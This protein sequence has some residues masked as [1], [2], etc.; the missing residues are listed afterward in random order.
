[1]K[2]AFNARRITENVWWVG[3]IDWELRN[4]H[5]YLTSQGSTYNAYLITGS[6]PIL[7]D[8]VR[9]PFYEEMMERIRSVI[10]PGQIRHVVSCHA[11]MDHSGALP[12]LLKEISPDAI[13]ASAPGAK[14][15]T[16]HFHWDQPVRV[17]KTGER[18]AFG[19]RALRFVET[20]MLHWPD[21]MFAFL[22]GDD[23]L[24]SNDAFGMHVASAERFADEL[25]EE[26]L[27]Y[28]AGKYFAN[29]L[30]PFSK[31]VQ[32]LLDQLPGL[33]LP[34]SV[35]APDHGPVW[36]T[37]PSRILEWYARWARRETRNKAVVI[38]SSM[39]KSTVRMAHAVGEGLE[40]GGTEVKLMPLEGSHRSDV[41]TE[42]LDA[43]A[44]VVGS[45]TM[46]GQVY[47]TIADVMTYLKGLKPV[48]LVAAAF[49]SYGWSGEAV[50][51]LEK[52]LADE[53]KARI[54][55][56][57]VRVRYVPT[58]EDL[59]RCRDLGAAVSEAIQQNGEA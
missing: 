14:A 17:V 46:N 56:P 3:A 2:T 15:L 30:L 7:V 36:R 26:L 33:D 4:L 37:N 59:A 6:E 48:N 27:E 12:P 31:L 47:P 57:G 32:R 29:I 16:D 13:Y 50:P 51:H 38:Y 49:G 39:W 23:V 58:N 54:P 41:A 40:A 1:M 19:D 20:R 10:D 55:A 5:G 34:I 43:A 25:S 24:F 8:T 21:S 18:L 9:A 42:V 28:E 53:M 44:L 52:I 22:E 11:E 45:P 35:I